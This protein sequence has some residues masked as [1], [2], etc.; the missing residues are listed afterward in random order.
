MNIRQMTADD[1]LAVV[2]LYLEHYNGKEDGCWTEETAFT[3]IRQVVCME[4]SYSLVLLDEDRII[5]FLMG[6]FKQYDD[7]LGYTLEE[8][9]IAPSLQNQGIGSQ[10]LSILEAHVREKGAALI[11][12]LAVND[13]QHDHFY[14][15]AGFHNTKSLIPKAKWL[16]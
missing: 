13:D 10:F 12:L 5:G 3:R 1:V 9:L 2:P 16:N 15:K 8:I 11:E 14:G 4:D 6:Y 7:I